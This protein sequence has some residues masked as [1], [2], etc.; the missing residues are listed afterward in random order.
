MQKKTNNLSF[1][2][3]IFVLIAVMITVVPLSI[4]LGYDQYHFPADSLSN[5]PDTQWICDQL[6]L[7]FSVDENGMI[8]GEYKV[9]DKTMALD[10]I[11]HPSDSGHANYIKC[12]GADGKIELSCFYRNI[13][14]GVF[15][16]TI[17]FTGTSVDLGSAKSVPYKFESQNGSSNISPVQAQKDGYTWDSHFITGLCLA[18]AC[19]MLLLL[20][21]KMNTLQGRHIQHTDPYVLKI[22]KKYR[23]WAVFLTA[24][25]VIIIACQ[26]L[27]TAIPFAVF[28]QWIFSKNTSWSDFEMVAIAVVDRLYIVIPLCVISCL[29]SLAGK[30][31][32]IKAKKFG[33]NA[34]ILRITEVINVVT[35]QV[36]VVI[37]WFMG[38]N[39]IA[40][41]I[42][43]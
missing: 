12:T 24:F 25:S 17:V 34:K 43:M 1:K 13:S 42:T 4:I 37:C 39:T 2:I 8:F 20:G 11:A 27:L 15:Y 26:L 28:V 40:Y 33:C 36:S 10:V 9:Q 38:L 30:M 19:V 14:E 16:A 35:Y 23:F 22:G 31:L 41:I 3:Y 32:N 21:R 6:A 7:K 29:V 5:Y 18:L